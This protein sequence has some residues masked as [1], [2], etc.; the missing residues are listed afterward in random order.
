MVVWVLLLKAES[1][2]QSLDDAVFNFT[3]QFLNAIRIVLSNAVNFP[4]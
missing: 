1:W 4:L 3:G 2:E